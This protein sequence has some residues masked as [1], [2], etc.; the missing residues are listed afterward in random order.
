MEIWRIPVPG[1]S[2]QR[3]QDPFSTNV[4]V[5]WYVPIIPAMWRNTNRRVMVQACLGIKRDHSI[6]KI[7]NTK[8]AGG[9]A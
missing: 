1:Q 3:L 7:T 6:S 2:W 8:R 4:W 9:V 5:W